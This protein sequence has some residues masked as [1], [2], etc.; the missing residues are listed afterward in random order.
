MLKWME[1]VIVV[2]LRVALFSGIAFLLALRLRPVIPALQ[3]PQAAG[4]AVVGT[5][6]ASQAMREQEPLGC[7]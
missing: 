5:V 6:E 4:Q 2:V 7:G 3:E 1:P